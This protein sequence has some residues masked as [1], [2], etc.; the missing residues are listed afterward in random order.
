[1]CPRR[2]LSR[3]PS[4][5][6]PS[7]ATNVHSIPTRCTSAPS[8]PCVSDPSATV[9]VGQS[10]RTHCP[11]RKYIWYMLTP[12]GTKLRYALLFPWSSPSLTPYLPLY[13]VHLSFISFFSLFIADLSK[14][15]VPVA[16]K[17]KRTSLLLHSPPRPTRV[18]VT[19]TI[20][21]LRFSALP[22]HSLS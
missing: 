2:S 3:G 1:M 15:A 11:L 5:R 13:L 4:M 19:G 22:T 18:P 6:T 14:T 12:I 7:R 17:L 10:V 9:N 20:S 16:L 21:F 8:S